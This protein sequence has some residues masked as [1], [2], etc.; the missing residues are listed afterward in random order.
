[1]TIGDDSEAS[2]SAILKDLLNRSATTCVL[3]MEHWDRLANE[4]SED[5]FS[6]ALYHMSRLVLPAPEARDTIQ[7]ILQHQD[8]LC[9]ALGRNVSLVT[10]MC[11]YFMQVNPLLREPILVEVNLLRQ[12]E[13]SAY[14]DELTGLFNRRSFNQEIPREMERFRRFGQPFTLLMLDLDHFKDF[15]DTYGHSAGDQVLRDVAQI[16]N[17]TARLYDRAVRYGGEEFA[18]ILPQATRE[19]ATGVAERIRSSM[20]RHQID[21]AGRKMPP[22]TVSIGL[23]CFPTDALDMSTLVQRADQA[24]YMA[25]VTRNSVR[26]F[27]DH[28]RNHTRYI[29]SDPLP[30][31]L[32]D[33]ANKM[34]AVARDISFGGLLCET[35]MPVARASAID[36]VLTDSVLGIRLPIRAQVSRVMSHGDTY[37][38]GLSFQLPSVE[39]Q[40]SL[41]ALIEGRTEPVPYCFHPDQ[42]PPTST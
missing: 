38:L 4:Y 22:V 10:A 19:E 7:A 1:M 15:N 16:L 32:S 17:D 13:E 9:Q 42:R 39:D 35:D 28:Q 40:K 30:V 37:Q 20:A 3:T 5:I 14:K 12:R 33:A 26:P 36:L 29:L 34:Y 21:F 2:F 27:C 11:D 41:M 23:A 24:L 31:R 6:E 25:K 8:G 18:V